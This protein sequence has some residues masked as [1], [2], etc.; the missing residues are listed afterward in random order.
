MS[1]RAAGF[2]YSLASLSAAT[3][4]E[5]FARAASECI[6]FEIS[7]YSA[8]RNNWPDL[9]S[10]AENSWPLQWCYGAPGIGLARIATIKQ[11]G[12]DSEFLAKDIA[13]AL[14]GVELGWPNAVDTLCCGTLCNVEFLCE[15]GNLLGQPDLRDLASRR[16]MSV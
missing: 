2:A 3:G 8:E 5:E 6:V 7:S 9:R 14:H 11:T 16:L 13:K 15:A 10:G 4:R 12:L 1:H